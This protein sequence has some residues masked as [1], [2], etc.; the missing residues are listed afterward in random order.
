MKKKNKIS[1]TDTKKI[2][3]IL[4]SKSKKND[5]SGLN[6]LKLAPNKYNSR[7]SSIKNEQKQ[8]ENN[9]SFVKNSSI[10]NTSSKQIK[11]TSSSHLVI[12]SIDVNYTKL[13][14]EDK[15]KIEELKEK[16]V[17][18]KKIMEDTKKELNELKENNDKIKNNIYDK[19]KELEKLK[20]E[21]QN[22]KNLND[23]MTAK[24]NEITRTIEEMNRRR[25]TRGREFMMNLL[26]PLTLNLL[27]RREE[28]YPNVDNMSYEELL[29]LEERMGKVSKGIPKEKIEKLPRDSFTKYKY[30]DDKCIICQYEFKNYER[31]IVLSCKHCY[32]PDCITQWLENHTA[33]PYCKNE[34][35]V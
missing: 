14:E 30:T 13:V 26:M 15:K 31:V 12:T 4:R 18:Q 21:K 22:I 11:N 17:Q 19:N 1:S 29:A 24:I 16:I 28:A 34:I 10:K 5:S 9:N 32:H 33:C 2:T 6:P 35:N 20:T 7:Y 23:E 27:R 25:Q 3:Y 8:N